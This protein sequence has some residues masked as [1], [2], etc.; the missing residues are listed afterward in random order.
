[1]YEVGSFSPVVFAGLAVVEVGRGDDDCGCGD[2]EFGICCIGCGGMSTEG[3]VGGA[4]DSDDTFD[5]SS[6]SASC[7]CRFAGL[8][9]KSGSSGNGGSFRSTGGAVY[10]VKSIARVKIFSLVPFIPVSRLGSMFWS[11]GC[12]R[13][14]DAGSGDTDILPSIPPC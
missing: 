6:G 8:R 10:P 12:G 7:R 13:V 11:T 3:C 2:I 1:M 5:S 9:S 14:V 4:F